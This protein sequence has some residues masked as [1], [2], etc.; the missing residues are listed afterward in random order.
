MKITWNKLVGNVKSFKAKLTGAARR[1]YYGILNKIGYWRMYF[2]NKFFPKEIPLNTLHFTL[3]YKGK[4]VEVALWLKN[5]KKNPNY[6]P[7]IDEFE[8][9]KLAEDIDFQFKLL[10]AME[11]LRPGPSV[12]EGT[13]GWSRRTR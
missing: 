4:S 12:Y 7:K 6:L 1:L 2:D 13:K 10:Q 5:S 8:I 11:S 9:E 3:S